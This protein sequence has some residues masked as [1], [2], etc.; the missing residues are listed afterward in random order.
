[1]GRLDGGEGKG[2]ERKSREGKTGKRRGPET[3]KSQRLRIGRKEPEDARILFQ[4]SS[5]EG[6]GM[7]DTVTIT[8]MVVE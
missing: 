3:G 2:K 5:F 6:F 4:M 8:G 7:S 1:M